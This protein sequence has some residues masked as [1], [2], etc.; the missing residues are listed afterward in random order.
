MI[1]MGWQGRESGKPAGVPPFEPAGDPYVALARYSFE[2]FTRTGRRVSVPD[3]L[4]QEMTERRAGTFVSLHEAG[5]LRGCIGTIAAT[6]KNVA[7]EIISNAIAACS[8]DPRFPPVAVYELEDIVC[9]VDVL[10]DAEPCT[11]ADLDPTRYGVIVSSGWARG[12]LLPDL[13]GV[14]T[15]EQ[16]VAIARRKAGI[17]LGEP[18]SLER[19]EV[20]RHE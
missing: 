6:E 20:I 7:E 8:R 5:E 13:E 11:R 19:F 16:Q 9:S 12:V 15:V 2:C 17:A 3:G 14:D 4:P 10:G 1:D 18:V